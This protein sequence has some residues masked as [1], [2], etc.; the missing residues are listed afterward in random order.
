MRHART[1]D[2]SVDGD[3]ARR[4]TPD[5]LRAAQETGLALREDDVAHV[6]CSPAT[7]TRQTLAALDLHLPT[8]EPVPVEYM[9]VLYSGGTDEIWTRIGEIDESVG[10]LLV[11]GHAPAIPALSAQLAWASDHHAADEMTCHFPTARH[12]R[13]RVPVTWAELAA[14]DLSGVRLD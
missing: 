9:E 14:G 7:R 4:L 6:L 13:F 10:T 2:H 11:V 3:R 8:G 5:G 1:E 12:T